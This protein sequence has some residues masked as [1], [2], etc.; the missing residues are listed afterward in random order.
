MCRDGQVQIYKTLL[1]IGNE[2]ESNA[3]CGYALS[4]LGLHDSALQEVLK[5]TER[6]PL[7]PSTFGWIR[8]Q[9]FAFN[10]QYVAV[11][12]ELLGASILNSLAQAF[13]VGAY[14]RLKR[15]DDASNALNDFI[16]MR[17]D[18]FRI[19]DDPVPDISVMGLAGG[20]RTMWRR[21]QDWEHI[22][23]GLGLAGISERSNGPDKWR[24]TNNNNREKDRPTR[25][26][27]IATAARTDDCAL[28]YTGPDTPSQRLSIQ[29]H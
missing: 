5:S 18:E 21:Q 9:V 13:L 1:K 16:L 27:Q 29:Y 10:G 3:W 23:A 24:N 11:V 22:A 6:D 14:A 17:K 25:P 15:G 20:F 12:E 7:P 4:L 26:M 28:S 19:R 8:G 2:V